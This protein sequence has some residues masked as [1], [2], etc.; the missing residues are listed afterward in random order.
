MKGLV[1]YK[2]VKSPTRLTFSGNK[3][4]EI[5]YWV[6]NREMLLWIN[7]VLCTSPVFHVVLT[8][9]VDL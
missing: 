7:V 6:V 4:L 8:N 9:Q 3:T 5:F 1:S 2:A